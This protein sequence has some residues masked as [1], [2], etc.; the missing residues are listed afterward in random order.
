MFS[1]NNFLV[2]FLV[3]EN[4]HVISLNYERSWGTACCRIPSGAQLTPNYKIEKNVA[5]VNLFFKDYIYKSQVLSSLRLIKFVRLRRSS[6]QLLLHIPKWNKVQKTVYLVLQKIALTSGCEL[7]I[8]GSSEAELNE[9]IV[10]TSS[11]TCYNVYGS[12]LVLKCA[13]KS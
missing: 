5:Y 3:M 12:L 4:Q 1:K 6:S 7:K 9:I 10:E 2:S 8:L 13:S 11:H